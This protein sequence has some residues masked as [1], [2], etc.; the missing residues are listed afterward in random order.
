MYV[1]FIIILQKL[2]MLSNESIKEALE[3]LGLFTTL[4]DFD[5]LTKKEESPQIKPFI[6]KSINQFQKDLIQ[7][8]SK[9]SQLN[10]NEISLICDTLGQYQKSDKKG[11]LIPYDSINFNLLEQTVS[12]QKRFI[13][14]RDILETFVDENNDFNFNKYCEFIEWYSQEQKIISHIYEIEHFDSS[15]TISQE[16]LRQFIIETI[17]KLA[18]E[19]PHT[20]DPKWTHEIYSLFVLQRILFDIDQIDVE[21]I[22]LA[23]LMRSQIF[24]QFINQ[25]NSSYENPVSYAGVMNLYNQFKSRC[26]DE[27]L[28]ISKVNMQTVYSYD[29]TDAFLDIL[30][31]NIDTK[32]ECATFLGFITFYLCLRYPESSR[33]SL[34]F[35][36]HILDLDGDGYIGK[37]DMYYFYKAQQIAS[38]DNPH[39]KTTFDLFYSRIFDMCGQ[40]DEEGLTEAAIKKSGKIPDIILMFIDNAKFQDSFFCFDPNSLYD[41]YD[42]LEPIDEY[43]EEDLSDDQGDYF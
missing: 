38:K 37:D 1:Y 21:K 23:L 5:L 33:H 22:S 6:T 13:F 20:T 17:P 43:E 4:D 28:T 9:S 29:F 10:E 27:S 25:Q 11:N 36:F 32:D 8:S 39:V 42:P 41:G 12:L 35:F 34:H 16:T 14:S 7:I 3:T 30:Y 18:P 15:K 31:D 24:R 26:H 19:Y 40:S 2:K